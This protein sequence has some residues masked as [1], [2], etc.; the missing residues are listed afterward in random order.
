M[1]TKHDKNKIV[2]VTFSDKEQVRGRIVEPGVLIKFAADGEIVAVE[3][4]MSAV[5]LPEPDNT[6]KH[7]GQQ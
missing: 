4:M 1:K 6:D 7:H 5:Q 2:K 3:I